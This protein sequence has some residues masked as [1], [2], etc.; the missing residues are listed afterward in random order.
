MRVARARATIMRCYTT[1]DGR[2][3]G[4]RTAHQG[5]MNQVLG[6]K[7]G[8]NEFPPAPGIRM[9]LIQ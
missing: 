5:M 9:G 3:Q 1:I 7:P 8:C 4:N 2:S 6:R